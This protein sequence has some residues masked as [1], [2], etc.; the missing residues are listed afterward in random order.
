MRMNLSLISVDCALLINVVTKREK[1]TW[2]S[3]VFVSSF[4]LAM[5]RLKDCPPYSFSA[6]SALP[7]AQSWDSLNIWSVNEEV[8]P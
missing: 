1:Q 8:V 5:L 6:I 3:S 7:Q 4:S 2:F